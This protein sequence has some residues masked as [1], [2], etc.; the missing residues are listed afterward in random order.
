M[1][2]GHFPG[3]HL[4]VLFQKVE[5]GGPLAISKNFLP[6]PLPCLLRVKESNDIKAVDNR[7][8]IQPKIYK[9]NNRQ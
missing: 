6:V 4:Y 5:M 1:K 8:V 2:V 7:I 9:L 3:S